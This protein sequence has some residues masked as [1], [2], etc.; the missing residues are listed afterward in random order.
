MN[1]AP[2]PGEVAAVLDILAP[3]VPLPPGLGGADTV[4][5]PVVSP[6]A[7]SVRAASGR[8]AKQ[9]VFRPDRVSTPAPYWMGCCKLLVSAHSTALRAATF[10][11]SATAHN[12]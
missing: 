10:R 8:I 9:L 3:E 7:A 2:T 4:R 12:Q 11:L 1:R 5:V 6:Q